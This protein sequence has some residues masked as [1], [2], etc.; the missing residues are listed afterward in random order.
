MKGKDPYLPCPAH[1][2]DHRAW[3]GLC[4][5]EICLASQEVDREELAGW[6]QH[7]YRCA[8]KTSLTLASEAINSHALH[9]D[10][11]VE[12]FESQK[13]AADPAAPGL[14]ILKCLQPH[15]A[16]QQAEFYLT[17]L[18]ITGHCVLPANVRNSSFNSFL[19]LNGL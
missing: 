9:Q 13:G 5:S 8:W 19:I 2:A 3:V 10:L 7:S 18:A 1:G 14:C 12:F 17:P 6:P 4:G 16:S 15:M 11:A